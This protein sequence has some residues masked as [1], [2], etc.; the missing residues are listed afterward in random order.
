MCCGKVD[1]YMSQTHQILVDIA[2]TGSGEIRFDDT[3][4]CMTDSCTTES[5]ANIKKKWKL[6]LNV[7]CNQYYSFRP[8]KTIII[9][10]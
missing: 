7:Q 10:M 4:S 8:F 1:T 2:G 5:I 6:I 9:I 3:T